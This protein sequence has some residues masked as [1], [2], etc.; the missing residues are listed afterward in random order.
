[1]ISKLLLFNGFIVDFIHYES[2]DHF[3]CTVYTWDIG[4]VMVL[5][6]VA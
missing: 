4:F 6:A 1:M 2:C 3:Q 5:Q